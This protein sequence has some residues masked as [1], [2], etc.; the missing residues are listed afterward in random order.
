MS[1][2]RTRIGFIKASQSGQQEGLESHFPPTKKRA[3]WRQK[4]AAT[5]PF[6]SNRWVVRLADQPCPGQHGQPTRI[7]SL[8]AHSPEWT[9]RRSTAASRSLQFFPSSHQLPARNPEG[10]PY[11][12]QNDAFGVRPVPAAVRASEHGWP[13]IYV[14]QQKQHGIPSGNG[15]GVRRKPEAHC[16]FHGGL[17]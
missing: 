16:Q 5:E 15:C 2:L 11:L 7:R 8:H 12:N 13:D 3:F 10:W 4:I 17:G 14:D 1:L 6:D 9:T